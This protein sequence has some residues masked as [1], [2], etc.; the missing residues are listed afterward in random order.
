MVKAMLT[1]KV[2]GLRYE[3]YGGFL[4]T[5]KNF[6]LPKILFNREMENSFT[7]KFFSCF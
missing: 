6:Y 5:N 7:I 4:C 2:Q 1:K 3:S